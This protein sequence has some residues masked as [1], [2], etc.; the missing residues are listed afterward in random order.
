MRA[1][2]FTSLV[3]GLVFGAHIELALWGFA[4]AF[5]YFVASRCEAKLDWVANERIFVCVNGDHPLR[6]LYDD[7]LLKLGFTRRGLPLG[8]TDREQ[9]FGVKGCPGER[10]FFRHGDSD[11]W[12]VLFFFI[13]GVALFG[14]R[15]PMVGGSG[16]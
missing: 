9:I 11:A 15:H 12:G 14:P 8:D 2:W 7:L 4:I 1:T 6:L 16:D 5:L 10:H 3:A 13:G